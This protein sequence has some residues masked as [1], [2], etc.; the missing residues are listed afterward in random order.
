MGPDD[1]MEVIYK[2]NEY[3][4]GLMGARTRNPEIP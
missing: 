2:G 1:R 3:V 4:Q